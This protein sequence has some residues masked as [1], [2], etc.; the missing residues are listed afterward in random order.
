MIGDWNAVVW[1]SRIKPWSDCGEAFIPAGVP[2]VG[3]WFS[4]FTAGGNLGG[5]AEQQFEAIG[6]V[7]NRRDLPA[8]LRPYLHAN[9]V[10]FDSDGLGHAPLSPSP[11]NPGKGWGERLFNRRAGATANDKSYNP[12]PNAQT[13]KRFHRPPAISG[14]AP[15]RND[16]SFLA[17]RTRPAHC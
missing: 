8:K 7:D 13:A 3:I 12:R 15:C 4:V 1:M 17:D 16:G 14:A 11:G 6:L 5:I 9:R 2:A 10:V